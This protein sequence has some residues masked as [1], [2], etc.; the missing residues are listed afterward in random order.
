[1]KKTPAAKMATAI[2]TVS[3]ESEP[4]DPEGGDP[5]RTNLMTPRWTTSVI[6]P[7]GRLSLF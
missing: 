2:Q 6:V 7:G 5:D 1:M 4:L 3:D